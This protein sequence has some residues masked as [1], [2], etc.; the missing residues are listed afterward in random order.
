MLTGTKREASNS[1]EGDHIQS[2]KNQ[3]DD[4]MASVMTGSSCMSGITNEPSAMVNTKPKGLFALKKQHHQH[5]TKLKENMVSSQ[6]AWSCAVPWSLFPTKVIESPYKS[7]DV[8]SI[9]PLG[10][11]SPLVATTLSMESISYGPSE[12]SPSMHARNVT[13]TR[14]PQALVG[15][16]STVV[17]PSSSSNPT[18][19]GRLMT[20]LERSRNSVNG[21]GGVPTSSND[22]HSQ[23][24]SSIINSFSSQGPHG[25]MEME[26]QP[27]FGVTKLSILSPQSHGFVMDRNRSSSGVGSVGSVPMAMS[28][29]P[30]HIIT[31]P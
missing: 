27:T 29:T 21:N 2:Q 6:N 8:P 9:Y 22:Q 18:M 7:A 28:G 5:E 19:A 4:D 12:Q 24:S 15:V 20:Y 13:N 17:V 26:G 10:T 3:R 23:P 14:N 30:L 31:Q 16:G 11:F 1:S 25:G